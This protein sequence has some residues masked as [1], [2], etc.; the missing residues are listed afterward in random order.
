MATLGYEMGKPKVDGTRR[1]NIIL[2]HKGKRKRM[3][4]DYSLIP[5]IWY[6]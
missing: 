1:V 2:S 6:S 3:Y 4:D 5:E